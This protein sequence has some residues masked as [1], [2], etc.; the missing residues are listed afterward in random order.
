MQSN[1]PSLPQTKQRILRQKRQRWRPSIS[2][3]GDF[4]PSS[5][6]E[7]TPRL[8]PA[9]C[10]QLG[11]ILWRRERQDVVLPGQVF[12]TA[13]VSLACPVHLNNSGADLLR[14]TVMSLSWFSFPSRSMMSSYEAAQGH[15]GYRPPPLQGLR[16]YF[17]IRFIFGRL[18]QVVVS[19][20]TLLFIMLCILNKID[21]FTLPIR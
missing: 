3:T 11:K 19:Q 5:R 13:R 17:L 12:V 10:E 7:R 4:V 1:P 8:S 9:I 14:P 16:Y 20:I 21:I 15:R 18:N 2:G 6:R